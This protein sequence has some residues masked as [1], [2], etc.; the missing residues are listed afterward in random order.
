MSKTFF[1]SDLHFWHNNVIGFCNRPFDS[2]EHMNK[3][4]IENWNMVVGKEDH[5]WVLG[6]FSFGT[7]QQTEEILSQLNGIKHLIVGN[8]DRKGRAE[9]L[10]NRDWEKWFVE[11]HD[12]FRFKHTL[13]KFVLCHFPLAS[14][15]R[16]YIN[17]HG[18]IHSVPDTYKPKWMQW[19]VGV[20]LNNYTPI[21]LEDVIKRAESG[22]KEILY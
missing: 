8:H 1:T 17:L 2:V 5:I 14:W 10:F 13:G 7:Y 20:D 12:Y 21:L 22:P 9:K 3:V 16:G 18:H 6:D 4:L 15:E 19:D 11:K